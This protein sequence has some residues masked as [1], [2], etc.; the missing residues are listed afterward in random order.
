[1][2]ESL[3]LDDLIR[4]GVTGHRRFD[5]VDAATAAVDRVVDAL[6]ERDRPAVVISALAE[7]ADRIVV[8]CVR[9]RPHT[10]LHAVLPLD[11]SEYARD[12]ATDA[13]KAEFAALIDAAE[14]VEVVETQPT[15]SREAAYQRA[16]EVMVELSDVVIALW[17]GQPARGLG[18]TAGIVE[19]ATESGVP[20]H[21]IRVD[22]GAGGDA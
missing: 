17:D 6:L 14:Q 16:G 9:R 8:D 4:I 18:G 21:V 10:W 7:G 2:G 12:F 13:S 1:M 22:R 5:H 20:V 19:L 11:P 15:D 3:Q